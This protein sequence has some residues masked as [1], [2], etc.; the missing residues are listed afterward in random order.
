[1]RLFRL[2]FSSL[3][4]LMALTAVTHAA[5]PAKHTP[6]PLSSFYRD[7]VL[8]RLE[9]SPD[10][11]HLL[12]LKNIDGI[13]AVMVYELATG[14]VFFPTKTDNKEFK[15]NWVRWANNDRLLMS[16]R[17]A[18]RRGMNTSLQFT[19]TRLL[20][21]DAKKPSKI[22]TLVKPNEDAVYQGWVSQFQD[23]IISMLPDD[24]E[25]ILLSVDRDLPGHQ[26]VY[27]AN[28][29]TGK[30]SRVK[31]YHSSVRSW[32]ADRQGNVRAGVGYNDR[33]RRIS[34]RVLDPNTNKWT[35]AWS[36]INFDEPDISP[37]G[38]GNDPN[39]LFL[40]ANHE[41]RQALF[42]ADLSKPGYPKELVLSHPEYDV[43][44]SLIYSPAHK[45]VV[46][47]YYNDGQS[48]SIFWN[49]EFKAFQAGL[50]KALPDS[51]N[52]IIS[53]SEDARKYVLYSSGNLNPGAIL[54]GNRDTKELV[55]V[56]DLL[57]ELTE[58][59][60]V[61]KEFRT[62]KARDG[63]ALEGYLSLPK[64][65]ANKPVATI[66]LPH[67]GPMSEDG[68]GF[69]RFSAF[70]VDR[71][72]AVFQ[73]NFRGSS[74]RGHDFMMQAIGGYGLEMQDDLEDA[75]HYLV[76][77]KIADP[78]KVCIVGA[79]YGGYAALMGATKTPDLFQCAISFA[80]MSDLVKMRD[81]FRYYMAAN[82]YREQF[83]NDRSQL[84]ET[85][86]A[87]M[88]DKVKIPIL[89]IHGDK[90]ASVPVAQSRLM[91]KALAKTK[92]TYEYIE[93]EDG[94]HHLDYLPHRQQTFEAMDKFLNQYLPL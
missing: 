3:V 92:K 40:F 63:L 22:I 68:S 56:A 34:I 49:Q 36:Y 59:V 81:T 87:R 69:D 27:K 18:S 17:F 7:E 72:Y 5:K 58:D 20:A 11:T 1:M 46:G 41:G 31:K 21:V 44:G 79:S 45:Q 61:K 53:L 77:E 57:P 38:F 76:R 66:I 14:N 73:P 30:L 94:T 64:T 12:A 10:G 13:T 62:Y 60:L 85:S 78:K 37:V 28:V 9:L 67:G 42:K 33:D 35:E 75:V 16:L 82:S 89:L 23:N 50:D 29:Y 86:P 74:G 19:E 70:M 32:L 65:F 52:Y 6:Q 39:E 55:H 24:P 43:S 83:G 47:I 48:K 4:L 2:I 90:D 25:H 8:D 15:F 93:L 88:V 80:G 71:G 26:T 54:Y 84:K 91:A 51:N